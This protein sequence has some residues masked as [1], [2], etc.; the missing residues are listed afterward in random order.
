MF[1]A[2]RHKFF[3]YDLPGTLVARPVDVDTYQAARERLLDA[4]FPY[5]NRLA[6][7]ETP[8]ERRQQIARLLRIYRRLHGE[9]FV[10]YDNDAPVGWSMGRMENPITFRMINS[11]LLP[12]YRRQGVYTAFTRRMLAYLKAIG[13]ERVTS[14]HHVNN[15]AVLTAKLKLGFVV[16]GSALGE[17]VGAVVSM[18]CHLYEDRYR[19]YEDILGLE[20]DPDWT[21]PGS[22]SD[23]G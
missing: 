1:D 10:F 17:D 4:V 14:H 7:F 3:P 12:A 13:Y 5:W 20:S 6:R 8:P 16:S 19:A 18:V 21:A 15:R 23:S 9:H 2:L 22:A 11:G